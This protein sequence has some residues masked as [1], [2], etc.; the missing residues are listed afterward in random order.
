MLMSVDIA[1]GSRLSAA[2]PKPLFRMRP[3]GTIGAF[4]LYDAAPDGQ[5]FLVNVPVVHGSSAPL[6]LVMDWTAGL[7]R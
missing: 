3:P 1:P 4:G 7:K 6:N 5:R 2:A